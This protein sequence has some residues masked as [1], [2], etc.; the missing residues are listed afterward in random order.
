MICKKMIHSPFLLLLFFCLLYE[1]SKPEIDP[2]NPYLGVKTA[3]IKTRQSTIIDGDTSWTFPDD[4][5]YAMTRCPIGSLYWVDQYNKF[6]QKIKTQWFGKNDSLIDWE[7]NKYDR[8]SRLIISKYY[9]S[10]HKLRRTIK[11]YYDENGLLLER[12]NFS[13]ASKSQDREIYTY[14]SNGIITE[15]QDYW[16]GELKIKDTYAINPE[17]KQTQKIR[18]YPNGDTLFTVNYFYPTDDLIEESYYLPENDS[19]SFT[20]LKKFENGNII[21]RTIIRDD[22]IHNIDRYEYNQN[23]QLITQIRTVPSRQSGPPHKTLSEHHLDNNGKPISDLIIDLTD[24]K[25]TI[26]QKTEYIYTYY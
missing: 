15:F 6:G 7:T 3:L 13:K 10:P 2:N 26:R 24:G 25:K 22:R 21:E 11:Y 18:C 14:N 20:L 23:N 8:N 17:G 19:L 4:R 1:C 5:I 16:N 12:S 9:Q